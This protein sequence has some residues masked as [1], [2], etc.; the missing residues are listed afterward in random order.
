MADSATPQP[1]IV[2]A[3]YDYDPTEPDELPLRENQILWIDDA[4]PQETG[5][6]TVTIKN[7]DGTEQTGTV[8]ETYVDEPVAL[9][10]ATAVYDYDATAPDELTVYEGSPLDVLQELADDWV[11]VRMAT[12]QGNY[13]G[14][15]PGNYVERS[16]DE[17]AAA[18]AAA[19]APE[20]PAPAPVVA[21]PPIVVAPPPPPQPVAATTGAPNKV[22][23]AL[24]DFE[25]AEDDDLDIREGETCLVLDDSDPDW[26]RVR[27]ISSLPERK[28]LEGMVPR[29]YLEVKAAPKLPASVG[30]S[31]AA[32]AAAAAA[33]VAQQQSQQQQHQQAAEDEARAREAAAERDRRRREQEAAEQ[34]QARQR[35]SEQQQQQKR[36]EEAREQREEQAR[37]EAAERDRRDAYQRKLA[38]QEELARERRDR[39]RAKEE[40]DAAAR[41]AAT[42]SPAPPPML[43][44]RLPDRPVAAAASPANN[45]PTQPALARI[46]PN[47]TG[48]SSTS[49]A[50]GIVKPDM[51]SVRVWL[52][53]S[54]THKTEAAYLDFVNG[55]V[56]LHKT[57]G[58]KID[59]PL[60][61]L[62]R[63]DQAEAYR[64]KGLPIP[65]TLQSAV[66]ASAAGSPTMPVTAR[67][68][69]ASFSPTGETTYKGMDWKE[70]L[71]DAGVEPGE[72]AAVAERFVREKLDESAVPDLNRDILKGLEVREGDIL[73]VLKYIQTYK[74]RRERESEL[75]QQNLARLAEYGLSRMKLSASATGSSIGGGGGTYGSSSSISTAVSAADQLKADEEFARRLQQQELLEANMS[76]GTPLAASSNG[77]T[78]SS[79]GALSGRQSGGMSQPPAPSSSRRK[80][81]PV[82]LPKHPVSLTPVIP[83]PAPTPARPAAAAFSAPPPMS[84]SVLPASTM[85]TI[86][87]SAMTPPPMAMQTRTLPA[88]LIPTQTG[89]TFVPTRVTGPTLAEQQQASQ[90]AARLA[91]Q[92]AAA[93]QMQQ[94]QMLMA[95]QAQHQR[96]QEEAK[97]AM[98]AAAM[99]Q[100][101]AGGAGAMGAARGATWQNATPD[102]PFGRAV[103]GGGGGGMPGMGMHQ[104]QQQTGM[105]M[106]SGMT[107]SVSQGTGMMQMASQSTGMPGMMGG[108]GGG[109]QPMMM[110]PAQM[111]MM[112]GVASAGMGM[113]PGMMMGQG[114]GGDGMHPGMM[115]AAAAGY[116]QMQQQQGGIPMQGTGMPS[117]YST[118]GMAGMTQD[119]YAA[120]RHYQGQGQR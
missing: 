96:Q 56:K 110:T 42:P 82:S 111:A 29:D 13:Y 47:S 101:P 8:P 104:Q 26:S 99:M 53:A 94:H 109:G 61:A 77:G 63:A 20:P 81:T 54:G 51:G 35:A 105:M 106:G 75:E 43:P 68:T 6:L 14:I 9:Y 2:Q 88:P 115:G 19:P 89:P 118:G 23:T 117:S 90:Q 55:M 97:R 22:A 65:A 46:M 83:L 50:S 28:G 120:L 112:G 93:Q 102:N 24:F 44:P 59:V 108:G 4:A 57:N 58:V 10:A 16:Q 92:Q 71:L 98:L 18:V 66:S 32:A 74:T 62:S 114:Q 11:V 39:E 34:Q 91:A 84:S 33:A 107:R 100:N 3:I 116:H 69:S 15:V 38:E 78:R 30:P 5:W 36:E 64:L 48:S 87:A 72:S 86:A 113:A 17:G 12:D 67:S 25:P 7:D 95:A 40:A 119:Q 52:D 37:Q 1:R 80:S 76:T 85:S 45:G 70:F 27:I 49:T 31:P 60:A 79:S 103:P 73:R 21:T 41:K